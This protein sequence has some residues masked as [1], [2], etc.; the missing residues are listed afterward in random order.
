MYENC[1][2]Q[3]AWNTPLA[4]LDALES[5]LNSWLSTEENRWFEPAT[6][7]TIQTI[8]YQRY[9]EIT[10]PTGHNG[11]FPF[12]FFPQ[13]NLN[14]HLRTWQDWGL[15]CQR[16]SAMYSALHYYTHQ[17]GIVAYEAPMPIVYGNNYAA[18]AGEDLA[19]DAP[20]GLYRATSG[21]S[22]SQVDLTG[23]TSQ[24]DLNASIAA[25]AQN[26]PAAFTTV[27]GKELKNIFGFNPPAS[28]R[29]RLRARRSRKRKAQAG[30]G[31]D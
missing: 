1:T 16:K 8:H 18:A 12:S 14:F 2:I 29:E 4:K 27:D 30:M 6:S 10:F 25:P 20:A 23:S 28:T 15:R 19:D 3:V 22:A 31:G 9:M 21:A 17:L 26:E 7:L 11:Y 13:L 5:C 24:V